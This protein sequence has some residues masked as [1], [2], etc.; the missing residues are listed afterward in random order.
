M[1]ESIRVLLFMMSVRKHKLCFSLL[2]VH[3]VSDS[4]NWKK[5]YPIARLVN[6][7]LPRASRGGFPG[8]GLI[9]RTKGVVLEG[10]VKC[11]HARPCPT[12]S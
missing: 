10:L 8:S 5:M 4:M 3:G 7:F 6:G 11:G 12:K 9:E 2:V 1:V